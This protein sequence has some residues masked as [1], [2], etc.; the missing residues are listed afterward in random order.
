MQVTMFVMTTVA[1][2]TTVLRRAMLSGLDPQNL[3][4]MTTLFDMA[5][6]LV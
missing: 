6:V 4:R 1:G 2:M 3:F 5:T